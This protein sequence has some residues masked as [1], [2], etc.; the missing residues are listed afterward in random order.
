[1]LA[2]ACQQAGASR[3]VGLQLAAA[4][5]LS[6]MCTASSGTAQ[7]LVHRGGLKVLSA[8]LPSAT[9]PPEQPEL[10]GQQANQV[11]GADISLSN[12]SSSSGSSTGAVVPPLMLPGGEGKAHLGP[13]P[14]A[15]S[16]QL[17]SPKQNHH[18]GPRP[19]SPSQAA[20]TTGAAA[21]A[22]MAPAGCKAHSPDVQGKL[23]EVLA[24]VLSHPAIVAGQQLTTSQLPRQL[25]HL[26]AAPPPKPQ[27]AALSSEQP[28]ATAGSSV[29][30][31]ATAAVAVP[32]ATASSQA[33]AV[34][35]GVGA[36]VSKSA[37][38]TP[39]SGAAAPPAAGGRA[40][41]SVNTHSAE[42]ASSVSSSGGV[43]H[44]PRKAPGATA[45]TAA[46]G[47][48]QHKVG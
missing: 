47:G 39:R 19:G 10:P 13:L 45:A 2:A 35:A 41:L 17:P 1:M 29:D 43:A 42:V 4:D 18:A 20:A 9:L 7:L 37:V 6:C 31:A 27:T 11:V 3:D 24:A 12:N 15:A 28:G 25:L 48:S 38:Q 34:K 32:Q 23:L 16:Q 21:S 8:L 36:P 22:Y 14:S 30:T 33:A 46:A 44:T 5:L 26:F 40:A